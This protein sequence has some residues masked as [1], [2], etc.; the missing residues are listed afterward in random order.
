[1]KI[2]EKKE[3][4]IELCDYLDGFLDTHN[5]CEIHIENGKTVCIKYSDGTKIGLCCGIQFGKKCKHLNKD[6]NG[7]KVQSLSCKKWLCEEAWHNLRL[8]SLPSDFVNFINAIQYVDQMCRL[9]N[10]PHYPRHSLSQNFKRKSDI[11]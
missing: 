1:M 7:C 2:Q 9:C 8:K 6:G 5:P 3:K 10:I 11:Y 4:Y